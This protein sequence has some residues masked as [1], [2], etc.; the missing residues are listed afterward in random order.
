MP[1][2]HIYQSSG[3]E[4]KRFSTE[5]YNR[6]GSISVGRS[7]KCDIS[8]KDFAEGYISRRHFVLKRNPDFW[9]IQDT[10]HIGIVKNGDKIQR[11]RLSIGDVIRFGQ[12]FFCYGDKTIPSEYDITWE[13]E[14]RATPCRAVLWPGVN[15]IG[16]S[17]DNYITIRLGDVSR[18]HG[19][20]S[21]TSDEVSYQNANRNI[22]TFINGALIDSDPI[23]ITTDSRILLADIPISLKK[24]TRVSNDIVEA[25]LGDDLPLD[26][27][28]E[29]RQMQK[30]PVP[31]L[32]ICLLIISLGFLAFL[33]LM[34]YLLLA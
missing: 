32:A 14:I 17:A 2:C 5:S 11:E 20:I 18:K 8:L 12:L 24:V 28:L 6:A 15:S 19:K 23:K 13:D 1:I 3:V 10:S 26:Q 34:T 21:V 33:L 7:S 31:F 27:V 25:N 4:V 16:A 9:E 22:K 29:M 30:R